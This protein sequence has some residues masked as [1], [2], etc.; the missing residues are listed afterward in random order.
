LFPLRDRVGEEP[1]TRDHKTDATPDQNHDAWHM[2]MMVPANEG[3]NRQGE[4]RGSKDE[5]EHAGE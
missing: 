1:P 2:A 3:Q 5:E 4:A